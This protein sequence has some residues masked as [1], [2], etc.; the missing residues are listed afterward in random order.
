[1]SDVEH[2][3]NS[4]KMKLLMIAATV[5]FAIVAGVCHAVEKAEWRLKLL[6]EVEYREG[7]EQARWRSGR[8]NSLWVSMKPENYNSKIFEKFFC[9]SLTE[10][11]IPSHL[12]VTAYVF[13][14][15]S[16]R[17]NGWP[18]GTAECH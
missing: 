16:Y 3:S 6:Q 8:K 2:P 12:E 17:S 13:D 14:P 5:C 11:G 7:V 9:Q 10:I 1:M 15:P 4:E 18:M